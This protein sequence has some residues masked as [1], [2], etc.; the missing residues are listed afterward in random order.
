MFTKAAQSA[1]KCAE[2]SFK[3]Q[4]LESAIKYADIAKQL[5]PQ[6]DGIDQLLV[7]YHV[8]V[9]ASKKRSNDES[10]WYAVLGL[11][12]AS[13]DKESIKKQ[14]KKMAIM[15]HPDKNGS[16]A[17]EGAF[18][19]ISEAWNVLSDPT[20]RKNYDLRSGPRSY[21]KPSAPPGASSGAFGSR[22]C[23]RCSRP[24]DYENKK[25]TSINCL[26]CGRRF[27]FR[28][29]SAKPASSCSAEASSSG[30]W[31]SRGQTG[32]GFSTYK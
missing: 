8:H 32:P 25:R 19:L 16:V 26:V 10:D 20:L 28:T 22:E 27:I 18:K 2:E 4:D 1:R 9:S 11:V 31:A 17:A 13:T 7:A 21:S 23:P 3:A 30:A 14:F 12:N 5:H 29:S 15:V 6:F 24:C